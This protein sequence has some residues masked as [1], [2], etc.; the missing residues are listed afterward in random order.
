MASLAL[1]LSAG[2]ATQAAARNLVVNGSFEP[3]TPGG[4]GLAGW[5][6]GGKSTDTPMPLPPVAIA[7]GQNSR[8]PTGAQGEAVPADDAVSADPDPA[9]DYGVY[10]VADHADNLSVYQEIYLTPGSYDIGFD[11][12]DTYNGAQEPNDA[13]LTAQIAGVTLADFNLSSVQPGSWSTHTG[14]AKITVAGEYAV[15]FVFNTKI[16]PAKD[17]VIDRAYVVPDGNGA[18]DLVPPHFFP[19]GVP[20]PA[21]WSLM[22]L[23]LGFAGQRLRRETRRAP[24]RATSRPAHGP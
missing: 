19:F 15:A 3:Q 14:E 12:Y 23:G 11:S 2:L 4:S 1:A 13:N 24:C 9:G 5:S 18:G 8:Y 7:Y 17:V 6:I 10:F 20:E 16:F 21:S 22:I